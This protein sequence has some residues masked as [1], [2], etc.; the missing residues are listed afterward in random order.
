MGFEKS[1]KVIQN[2][3]RFYLNRGLIG[4]GQI[5]TQNITKVLAVINHQCSAG[6][7][8]ALTGATTPRQ[9]GDTRLFC[10]R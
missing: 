10:N 5:R 7:L 8:A 3:A 1:V 2:D 9:N 6:R 4:I